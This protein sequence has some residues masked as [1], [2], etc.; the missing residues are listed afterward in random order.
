MYVILFSPFHKL[1]PS[2]EKRLTLIS[3]IFL[4]GFIILMH[5]FDA[6]LKNEMSPNGMVS[7]ELAKTLSKSEAILTSWDTLATASAKNSMMADFIFLVVYS[8]FIALIIHLLN[9]KV[10]KHGFV[11]QL[12][13]IIGWLIFVA[14]FFDIIENFA[15]VKLLY[16]DLQQ[17]WSSIAYYFA[18][19][20]FGLLLLGIFFILMSLVALLFKKRKI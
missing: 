11:Y 7:F 4:I 20:K 8:F 5:F 10:W 6:P 13:I 14:A 18:V 15:L 12:G 19:M 1:K 17:L 9:K 2:L 3:L 16:G